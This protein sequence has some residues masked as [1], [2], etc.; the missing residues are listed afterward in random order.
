MFPYPASSSILNH[1]I[2]P[3]GSYSTPATSQE[4]QEKI[5]RK[6]SE[7]FSIGH[8]RVKLSLSSSADSSSSAPNSP[9]PNYDEVF[10]SSSAT[11]SFNFVSSG[12][13]LNNINN[14]FDN[15]STIN[16]PTVASIS[17]S[18]SA[19]IQLESEKNCY[20]NKTYFQRLDSQTDVTQNTINIHQGVKLQK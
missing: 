16:Q 7:T 8:G 15:N 17:Y 10:D 4:Q 18:G 19:N 3:F 13:V 11:G 9:P 12:S 20:D 6:T 1:S 2:A 5:Q 14:T